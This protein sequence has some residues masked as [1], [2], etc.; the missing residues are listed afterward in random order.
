MG[1]GASIKPAA[2]GMAFLAMAMLAS[3][4]VPALAQTPPNRTD[5]RAYKGLLSAVIR[6]DLAETQRLLAGG[7]DPNMKDDAGRTPLMI[8]AHRS[9]KEIARAL[10]KGGADPKAKDHQRYDIITIAAVNN[11]LEFV[12]LALE[13][14]A[15]PKAITSPYDGTALIATAH[16]GHFRI[17]ADLIAAGAPLDHVNNLGMTALIEAI[18][19]GD[20]DHNHL[21]TVKLLLDAGANPNIADRTRT[22]PLKLAQQRGYGAMADI[23]KQAG[24]K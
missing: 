23:I 3:S 9:L 8:A 1:I 21:T 10:V 2:G 19:L 13:L 17:V 5:I 22:S 12:R 14:G 4:A 11:D 18:T 16:L 15:D 7:A 20:G 24:G 6:S